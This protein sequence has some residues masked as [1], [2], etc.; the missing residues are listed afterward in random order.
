MSGIV[1]NAT[2]QHD[3]VVDFYRETMGATVRLEQPDCAILGYDNMLFGFCERDHT[4][5]C[6]TIT[7]VYSDPDA[8]DEVHER[9]DAA[10]GADAVGSPHR[11]DR[12]DIYQFFAEDP[13]GRTVECQAFLD[14]AVSL[15]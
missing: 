2:E 5:D 15:P 14:D 8:V 7:F 9:L 13:D 10:P 11:N 12:Y 4:D 1:F 6:G 3:A